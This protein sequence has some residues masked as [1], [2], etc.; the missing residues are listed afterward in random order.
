MSR[1]VVITGLGLIS[2]LGNS[3][4]KLWDGLSRGQSAVHEL[5]NDPATA[6]QT[7]FA[8][9]ARDF[10]GAIEDFGPLEKLLARNIKKNLKVMCREIQMGVAVAQLAVTDAGLRLDE[11][12]RDR[13]GVL[14]GS[15]YMLSQPTEF[16]AAV[17]Q[18]LDEEGRFDFSRWAEKGLAEVEPLWLL[19][20]L[21]NL[22]ACHVTIFNDLRGPNNSITMRES[23]SN[24]A[25][26]EAYCTIER[27]HADRMIAGATG[28]RVHPARTLNVCLQEQIAG[29][30]GEAVADPATLSRPFDKHRTGQVLG[31]GAGAVV[32][33]ELSVAQARGAKIVGEVIGYGSS[34]V[35]SRQGVGQ[36]R[37][38]LR[39]VM[40]QALRSAKLAPER[41]GHIHAHG[42]GTLKS[43]AEEAAAI[44]DIFGETPVPVTA[45]K[46]YFGNLGAGGG[47]VEAIAS[48]LALE[49]QSLF[50]I[51]NY[52]TPDPECP[53]QAVKPG[54]SVSAG[55]NFINLSV[56]P[57]GQ[58]SAIVV[59]RFKD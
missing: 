14:Y 11:L 29:S 28:T 46:S 19:K 22:P 24:I 20:Y 42:L 26:A 43:D 2:P 37:V 41:V 31:E 5:K 13:I 7:R 55:D 1:R 49:K 30:D 34:Q 8:A 39:N 44:R 40:T 38:A 12:D 52:D 36:L 21:P 4:E 27:G 45:A 6:L 16:T 3:A 17:R 58:A 50:P 47:I 15:D 56:T 51:L 35:V 10:T 53:I 18:C 48:L 54:K 57:L 33:E 9:E 32:L 25:V 23:A 59:R